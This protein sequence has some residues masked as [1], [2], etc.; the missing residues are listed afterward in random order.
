MLDRLGI[1]PLFDEICDI[2]TVGFTA[3]PARASYEAVVA[4]TG[5]SAARSAMFEDA[6]RN[7]APAHAMGM[8]TVWLKTAPDADAAAPPHVHHHTDDL[9]EFLHAI[10][11]HTPS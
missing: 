11:V 4:R 9:T 5:V 8:T 2:R 3:K 1:A 6:E 7:L 10:E